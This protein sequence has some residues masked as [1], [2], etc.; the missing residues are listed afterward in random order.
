L[1]KG[2]GNIF[3]KDDDPMDQLEKFTKKSIDPLEVKYNVDALKEFSKLQSLGKM[4]SLSS[5]S[6]FARDL[7]KTIPNIEAAIMGGQVIDK[8]G[9]GTGDYVTK[10]LASG[11]IKFKEAS[12]NISE[13][14]A[15][16]GMK[17]KMPSDFA[18]DTGKID[19]KSGDILWQEKLTK[20]VDGLTTALMA[21]SGGAVNNVDASTKTQET[22]NYAAA[23]VK[24]GPNQA[25]LAMADVY[26]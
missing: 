13:L 4:P 17:T 21:A 19:K 15:S 14:R 11:D 6:R 3:G 10:G 2:F 18:S 20:S 5:W 23:N 1:W 7:V 24:G 12:I 9:I 8:A 22:K 25:V 16:L 26:G